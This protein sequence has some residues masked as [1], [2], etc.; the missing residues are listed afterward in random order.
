MY[1]RDIGLRIKELLLCQTCYTLGSQQLLNK[2][3]SVYSMCF[4]VN[5]SPVPYLAHQTGDEHVFPI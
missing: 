4:L 1:T 2:L 5:S 3:I